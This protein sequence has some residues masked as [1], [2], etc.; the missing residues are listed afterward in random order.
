VDDI[1]VMVAIRTGGDMVEV[2]PLGIAADGAS[3]GGAYCRSRV[4]YGLGVVFDPQ[5]ARNGIGLTSHVFALSIASEST[6]SPFA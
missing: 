1:D 6:P 5:R 2:S 4:P 3:T